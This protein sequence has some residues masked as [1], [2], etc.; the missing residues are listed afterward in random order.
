MTYWQNRQNGTP[1]TPA[2]QDVEC[3]NFE[4]TGC[5]HRQVFCCHHPMARDSSGAQAVRTD[6]VECERQ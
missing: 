3:E 2:T 1:R 4:V 5:G 6:S